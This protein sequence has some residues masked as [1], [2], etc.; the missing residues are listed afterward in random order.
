MLYP[1]FAHNKTYSVIY[2]CKDTHFI[3]NGQTFIKKDATTQ[4]ILLYNPPFS[5][6]YYTHL[7]IF[8]NIF[9]YFI[10]FLI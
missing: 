8:C 4:D 2:R 10:P 6:I 1:I 7:G 5:V 3:L 9:K